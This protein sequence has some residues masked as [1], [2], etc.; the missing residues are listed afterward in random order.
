MTEQ[1][2]WRLK[3]PSHPNHPPTAPRFQ[4]VLL[5][6]CSCSLASF[7]SF[8]WIGIG[9]YVKQFWKYKPKRKPFERVSDFNWESNSRTRPAR[10][11]THAP[12]SFANYLRYS[13][14]YFYSCAEDTDTGIVFV[15]LT[16]KLWMIY[17]NHIRIHFC[18][19]CLLFEWLTYSNTG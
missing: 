10:F 1:T 7:T 5:V 6:F 8:C 12:S 14:Q 13:I 16:Y 19:W 18:I 2:G 17:R 3:S 11:H 15:G 4:F 9:C